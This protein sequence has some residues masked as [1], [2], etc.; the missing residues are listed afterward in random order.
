MR[1]SVFETIL[2]V[3]ANEAAAD[4]YH[5]P[6]F[7]SHSLGQRLPSH[8]HRSTF[9]FLHPYRP[10]EENG[11][12]AHSSLSSFVV[13]TRYLS[14]LL[15]NEHSLSL[16]RTFSSHSFTR[17]SAG[18][19]LQ[20]QMHNILSSPGDSQVSIFSAN[21]KHRSAD[22]GLRQLWR[23]VSAEVRRNCA[24]QLVVVVTDHIR[25]VTQLVA[26][27]SEE[28]KGVQLGRQRVRVEVMMFPSIV[29]GQASIFCFVINTPLQYM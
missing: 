4:L 3:R 27:F 14:S 20:V 22:G 16:F 25:A 9:L 10:L 29:I 19:T 28:L 17:S 26:Q 5:D 1:W 7:L 8:S 6:F 2:E 13:P 24:W 18:W 11:M 12:P 15:E 23:N 21:D